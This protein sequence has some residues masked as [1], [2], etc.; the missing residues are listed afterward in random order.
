MQRL[1]NDNIK[2]QWEKRHHQN[3]K[4]VPSSSLRVEQLQRENDT[5]R[6]QIEEAKSKFQ[7]LYT[8][9]QSEIQQLRREFSKQ[10]SVRN[11]SSYQEVLKENDMLK[12]KLS[13]AQRTIRQLQDEEDSFDDE[14]QRKYV[15]L[16]K[17]YQQI[18][19][20]L[21]RLQTQTVSFEKYEELCKQNEQLQQ[22][23]KHMQAQLTS[24]HPTLI[25]QKDDD[26][27]IVQ[28]CQNLEQMHQRNMERLSELQKV[29]QQQQM[30]IK[31][32]Q[33]FVQQCKEQLANA[34]R[35]KN[36]YT[37][38]QQKYQQLWQAYQKCK[39]QV[40]QTR[41]EQELRQN[42]V[43][44][45]RDVDASARNMDPQKMKYYLT[46]CT[47]C[48]ELNQI[49][50]AEYLSIS[51]DLSGDLKLFVSGNY[52]NALV[53]L[54]K[55]GELLPNPYYFPQLSGKGETGEDLER[56]KCIFQFQKQLFSGI[57]YVIQKLVPA[58]CRHENNNYELQQT[59][60]IWLEDI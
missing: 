36:S 5:L 19:E 25:Q 53:V 21:K 30:E 35:L 49:E 1:Q 2:L 59:G 16:M 13:Y 15:V 46:L 54:L 7:I 23:N 56:L 47:N 8:R 37:E 57:R 17:N 51:V 12:E 31:H 32:L 45:E 4:S 38:L 40:N 9:N 33:D 27:E 28:R 42:Y 43:P 55:T 48:E 50:T 22:E 3:L 41:K 58:K 10:E 44:A 39:E 29:N 14:R 52:R 26:T 11:I 18:Q 60:E 24:K 6:H 34:Q 20:Q